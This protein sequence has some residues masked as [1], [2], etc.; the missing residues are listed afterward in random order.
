MILRPRQ[1]TFVKKCT[2]ALQKR[3]NTIGVAPTGAG[4]TVCMAAT[5]KVMQPKTNSLPTMVLQ[6]RE[7][8]VHQNA[9]TFRQYMGG[10]ITPRYINPDNKVFD[11]SATG[12]N[13]AMVQTLS[14]QSTLDK[15][16]PIGLLM[17]DEAHH[18]VA[19]SYMRV[20]HRA[21][22]LNPN[23][24]IYGTTATPARGDKRGLA[25]IFDNCADEITLMELISEGH[26]VP[27]KTFVL[28]LGVSDDLEGTRNKGG[29]Y[30][31]DKVA[32][33]FN[34][35]EIN[36]QIVEKWREKAGNRQ[37]VV[38]CSNVQHATDLTEQFVDMG[39]KAAM[40]HGAMST[41]ERR[42][43][44]KEY[45]NFEHQV[46][47]NVAVLTE[48]FDNQP[49]SC[50]LI[51]RQNSWKSTLLQMIGRGLRK[52]D[53][54][55]YPGITKD[56]CIV[57]DFGTSLVN[58]GDIFADTSLEGKGVKECDNCGCSLPIQMY[59]CPLCGFEFDTPELDVITD[60]VT[61]IGTDD[62]TGLPP[63]QK[64]ILKELDIINQSP[65]KYENLYAGK[66]QVC[67]AFTAWAAI[68]A[69]KEGRFIAIGGRESNES[70]P[71]N[72]EVHLL[73]NSNSSI[74]SLQ[75]ADDWMRS[76]GDKSVGR[77]NKRW[78]SL[79]PT[80]KQ[81]M[82][83]NRLKHIGIDLNNSFGI[84]RYVAACA[85]TWGYNFSSIES[86][87]RKVKENGS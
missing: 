34:T 54:E 60:E 56:D 52:L 36:T 19:P 17:I 1:E 2:D 39:V 40:V 62:D 28:D 72:K 77:K 18:A 58:Y 85:L 74:L 82:A 51:V 76:H 53:P 68:V 8:L 21:K 66:V 24:A 15:M 71:R 49:T 4:K 29:A 33:I 55:R 80:Q 50:V 86:I 73:C 81:L 37:T 31:D 41:K 32:T 9:K 27:P 84:N 35:P 30:D 22:E 61:G 11:K 70:G 38:F 42:R 43:I 83:L 69:T 64:I 5:A 67:C 48:G 12:C 16:P 6:H 78:L 46:L 57:I 59:E 7:E 14:R 47:L 45:D 10:G 25:A 3:K 44:L 79:P 63:H 20:I 87:V 65:F 75:S 23:L 13:F 26:L